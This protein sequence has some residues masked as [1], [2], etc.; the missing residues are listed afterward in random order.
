[1]LPI[2]KIYVDTR[3]KTPDSRSNSDF[4]VQLPETFH[5]PE[6]AIF[7]VDDIC[8]PYSW[9][10]IETDTNDCLY[11]LVSQNSVIHCFRLQLP[12]GVYSG[13]SLAIAIKAKLLP[14]V[15][16]FNCEYLSVTNTIKITCD[17]G[18]YFKVLTLSDLKTQVG[19][20]WNG[21]SYDVNQP[22]DINDILRNVDSVSPWYYNIYDSGYLDLHPIRNIYLQSSNMGNFNTLGANGE[23]NIIKKIP[24]TCNAGELIYDS[25]KSSIDYLDCSKQTLRTLSFQLKDVY[26]S[27]INLHNAQVSFSL[28]FD[29]MRD[30]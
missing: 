2:K 3:H 24:V 15:G 14:V 4:T 17:V 16:N 18:V 11:L 12:D 10:T 27:V 30:K 23:S 26:G 6:N 19:G 21:V 9:Y 1:M 8:I 29:T 5:M 20:T 25:I 22:H 7:Y 28:I 13:Y